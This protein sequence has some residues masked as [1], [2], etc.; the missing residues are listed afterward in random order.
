MSSLSENLHRMSNRELNGLAQNRFTDEEIQVRLA[1]HHYLLCR[2]HLSMNPS[3][4]KKAVDVLMGGKA[5]SVKWNLV[6]LGHLNY[7][8]S[9][10]EKVYFDTPLSMMQSWRFQ[11]VFISPPPWTNALN[12][13]KTPASVLKHAFVNLYSKK[14]GKSDY[15]YR[16]PRYWASSLGSHPNCDTELAIRMSQDPREEVRQSGFAALVRLKQQS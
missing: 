4:C 8:P 7:D 10:I 6:S 13:P 3:L 12:P 9:L 16:H 11:Y 5:R 14:D 1:S 2:Q 15:Y